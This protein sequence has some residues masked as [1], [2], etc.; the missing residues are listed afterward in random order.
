MELSKRRQAPVKWLHA[1]ELLDKLHQSESI[2]Q[3]AAA[4][5]KRKGGGEKKEKH[6]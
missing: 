5:V 6:K 1:L 4:C 2:C 3:N